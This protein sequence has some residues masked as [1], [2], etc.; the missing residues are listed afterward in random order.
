MFIFCGGVG[1]LFEPDMC[2][3]RFDDIESV[4]SIRSGGR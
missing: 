4:T 3:S 2:C 1:N